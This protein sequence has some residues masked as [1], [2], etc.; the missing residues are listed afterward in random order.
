VRAQYEALKQLRVAMRA[1]DGLPP[2]DANAD[3]GR[4]PDGLGHE[5]A[6]DVVL[7]MLKGT[8]RQL[9]D[10]KRWEFEA[11][12]AAQPLVAAA[13]ARD[14]TGRELARLLATHEATISGMKGSA[15]PS[16]LDDLALE[17]ALRDVGVRWQ[18]ARNAGEVAKAMQWR[19]ATIGNWIGIPDRRMAPAAGVERST[20]NRW[21]NKT[22]RDAADAHALL[23]VKAL[24]ERPP[25]GET[26]EASALRLLVVHAADT[27]PDDPNVLF[28]AGW[29]FKQLGKL[30][31][32]EKYY[33][34]A[35]ADGGACAAHNLAV[36][37]EIKGNFESAE[38]WFVEA[39]KRGHR[40]ANT[41]L[42]GDFLVARERIADARAVWAAAAGRDVAAAAR[43]LAE[44]LHAS[45]EHPEEARWWE[46]AAELGDAA[47]LR[48]RGWR[49]WQ[50]GDQEASEQAYR[51]AAERGDSPSACWLGRH[52][53]TREPKVAQRFLEAASRAGGH[54]AATEA[55]ICLLHSRNPQRALSACR[56]LYR[57]GGAPPRVHYAQLLEDADGSPEA[58]REA[59]E[60]WLAEI[61]DQTN[62][63][64]S[65]G[66]TVQPAGNHHRPDV[67]TAYW[68]AGE[69]ARRLGED[70]ARRL[71]WR[72]LETDDAETIGAATNELTDLDLRPGQD[73]FEVL[74]EVAEEAFALGLHQVALPLA[75]ARVAAGSPG[76]ALRILV[77]ARQHA[78]KHSVLAAEL[79]ATQLWV[80]LAPETPP[81]IYEETVR[82]WKRCARDG[83][84]R[85][86][87]FLGFHHMRNNVEDPHSAQACFQWL[88]DNG[89]PYHRELAETMLACQVAGVESVLDEGIADGEVDCYALRGALEQERGVLEDALDVWTRGAEAG[90]WEC[91]VFAG[92]ALQRAGRVA[93]ARVELKRTAER[94]ASCAW[95]AL[96]TLEYEERGRD[97]RPVAVRY[98]R[99]AMEM[100]CL[101]GAY[102]LAVAVLDTKNPPAKARRDALSA[103]RTVLRADA[104]DLHAA[105]LL[106]SLS[107]EAGAPE[108]ATV[109]YDTAIEDRDASNLVAAYD[110][111]HHPDRRLR[112]RVKRR[113]FWRSPPTDPGRSA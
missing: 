22:P 100:G 104:T 77:R 43:R 21:L 8:A 83:S 102:N 49:L 78:P 40:C 91:G 41:T 46:R 7:Q 98:F 48:A 55:L 92:Q 53:A 108:L 13:L 106:A 58:L 42:H 73:R 34:R 57:Q 74:A 32:A 87:R 82:R 33:E 1:V 85:A 20:V 90:D 52:L 36:I 80:A 72:A 112:R 68:K 19:W 16:Q 109:L 69:L 99:R 88:V 5:I 18:T 59:Y 63:D 47:G 30:D 27:H 86:Y 81:E 97:G 62:H 2:P 113:R 50:E 93:E 94:G 9:A 110:P 79:E 51:E 15:R 31:I 45:D 26:L 38:R 29:F 25:S 65:G 39:D 12:R 23:I 6:R 89:E 84:R 95:S 14:M 56:E 64:S 60:L 103:V 67:A 96:G 28:A 54:Q 111:D 3:H 11:R 10:A 105:R 107:A 4:S 24:G 66:A 44:H 101:H 75:D 71:L 17:E 61:A 35:V 76:E 37:Y 70:D